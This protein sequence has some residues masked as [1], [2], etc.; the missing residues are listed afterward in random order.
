MIVTVPNEVLTTPAKRVLKIDKKVKDVVK[1]LKTTLINTQNPKGVGLAASQIG[2]SLQIFITRPTEKSLI[3]VFIN[4]EITW[5]SER[6]AEIVRPDE[7]KPSLRK[8]RTCL[9]AG[10]KLEGCLSIPNIWGYLKRP[11]KVRLRFLDINGKV[12][13]KEFSGFLATIVQHETDHLNG[14]LFTKRVLEQ[15]EKFYRIEED[16]DGNEK[17]VEVE[18]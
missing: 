8:E 7:G 2:I 17:L 10:R 12:E 15:S 13:E 3:D 6:L 4:P 5:R 14:I 16:K 9:P 1:K 11:D 18:I